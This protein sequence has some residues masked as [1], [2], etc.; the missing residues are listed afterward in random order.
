M[1]IVDTY[2]DCY[3]KAMQVPLYQDDQ[4]LVAHII[5]TNGTVHPFEI[6][7]WKDDGGA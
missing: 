5:E 3:S 1:S 4:K 2:M 6:D 7:R